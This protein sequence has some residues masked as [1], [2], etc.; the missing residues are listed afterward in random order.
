LFA[1]IIATII[2]LLWAS[3]G[4]ASELSFTALQ[5][6]TATIV[7]VL[8]ATAVFVSYVIIG[9]VNPNTDPSANVQHAAAA[10][11]AG[12]LRHIPGRT[13]APLADFVRPPKSTAHRL[14]LPIV[15]LGVVFTGSSEVIRSMNHWPLNPDC[16][17]SVV[18]AGDNVRIYM[19]ESVDTVSA[20]WR[21][22]PKVTFTTEKESSPIS[23]TASAPGRGE[24]W[25]N[26]GTIFMGTT[27]A[28]VPWVD[29]VVPQSLTGHTAN[30]AIDLE[31]IYPKGSSSGYH[32]ERTDLKDTVII[33]LAPPGVGSIFT[34]LWWGTTLT[35]LLCTIIGGI[36]LVKAAGSFGSRA[37][38]ARV[39][40]VSETNK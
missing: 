25:E 23:A 28:I 14:A 15:L 33:N 40:E 7:M 32:V 5:A 30:C 26:N 11:T 24:N 21:G 18:G 37:L 27:E 22:E 19:P 2:T 8:I 29:I 4:F 35:G 12:L 17:P 10:V 13:G 39:L 34:P 6:N 31:L 1:G 20:F 16:I 3:S 9:L 36:L 38:P